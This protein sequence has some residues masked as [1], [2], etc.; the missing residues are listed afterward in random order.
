MTHDKFLI[1]DHRKILEDS[2]NFT[3]K[4]LASSGKMFIMDDMRAVLPLIE[5][6]ELAIGTARRVGQSQVSST[7]IRDWSCHFPCHSQHTTS[8]PILPL[9]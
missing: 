7:K 5:D 4:A 2:V 8:M 6:F 9:S 3:R 1:I